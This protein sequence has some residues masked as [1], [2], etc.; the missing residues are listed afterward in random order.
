MKIVY[1][2]AYSLNP[3]D[4]SWE[5]LKH[6]GEFEVYD[7]SS[8][9]QVIDRAKGAE[10]VLTNKV[11]FGPKEFEGLKDN[12]QYIAVTATGYNIIDLEAAGEHNILV[13]NIPSYGTPSVAQHTISL[14]LELTN[15]IGY[16]SEQVKRGKWSDSPDFCF[17]DRPIMELEGKTL[18]IVG[19]G[20]IGKKVARIAERLGMKVIAYHP[21]PETKKKDVDFVSIENLFSQSDVISLHVPLTEENRGFVNSDLLGQMKDSAILINTARGELI[22]EDHLAQALKQKRIRGAGLDVLQEEPP[23]DNHKLYE[24]DNCIITPHNAWAAKESRQRLMDI[25]IHNIKSYKQADPQ[26]IVNG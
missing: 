17:W 12:L 3:G 15:H 16:H 19:Y 10:V 22:R 1:L 6:F 9:E 18:G 24:L 21:R 14:I 7:R 4:L 8:P 23:P 11:K 13:S 20:K 25:L 26:N 2:D 5:P